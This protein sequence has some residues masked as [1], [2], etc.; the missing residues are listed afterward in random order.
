MF[1][2]SYNVYSNIKSSGGGYLGLLQFK[3]PVS[4][5]DFVSVDGIKH[6]VDRVV[7]SVGRRGA[8]ECADIYL[9]L[10]D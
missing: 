2:I 1:E 8:S 5:G 3:A 9:L 6:T 10:V 7:H 4:A